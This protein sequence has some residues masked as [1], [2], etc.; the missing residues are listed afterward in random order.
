MTQPP[1]PRKPRAFRLDDPSVVK[2]TPPPAPSAPSD[3][4]TREAQTDAGDGSARPTLADLKGG[5]RWGAILLSAMTGLAAL[6]AGVWFA[7][8]VSVALARDDWIGWAAMALLAAILVAA[9][10]I[11]LREIVGLSRLGRLKGLRRD[12][13]RALSDGD[14]KAEKAAIDALRP[15]YEGRADCRWALR[16]IDEHAA[17]V[18]DPGDLL[19][20]ADRELIAPLDLEAR[21]LVMRSAKRVGVVSAMSPLMFVAVL[22]V[23]VENVR[24][25]RAIASLYG[26]QPGTA[27]ALRLG[28]MVVGHLLASG[29]VALTEDLVG[30]F[31]GQDLLRRLSRRLGEAAFNGA[32]TARV[33]VAAIGIIRPLPY[34]EATP[35]RVRELIAEL[36]RKSPAARETD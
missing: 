29:G 22:F 16:R 27:G 21:R 13:D 12:A 10:A 8:F 32:L 26:G 33:G 14:V 11:L 18:R 5:I 9:G 36:F 31:L 7:R 3:D 25:L 1:E 15:L 19:K 23:L 34:I 2:V 20:L 28:R 6:A 4:M 30:Q 24:M 35:V 17:D